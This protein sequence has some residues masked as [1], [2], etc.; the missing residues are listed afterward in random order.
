M[1]IK[2][3]VIIPIY[4]TCEYIEECLQS[5]CSQTLKEIEIICVDDGS[6]DGSATIVS[7]LQEKD[8]RIRLFEQNKC[9]SGP[10]RNLGIIKSVGEFIAFMDSDD[11]YP[12][13]KTLENMYIFAKQNN[14]QICGGSVSFCKNKQI[15]PQTH[16]IYEQGYIFKENSIMDYINYQFDHGYWRFIYKSDLIKRNSI[17]FP[18]FLRMQDPPFFIQAMSYSKN[19]YA[20]KEATYVY[21]VSHKKVQWDQHKAYDVVCGYIECLKISEN[22]GYDDLHFLL[23][24]RLH[25]IGIIKIINSFIVN[26]DKKFILLE[27]FNAINFR[28]VF[29]KDRQFKMHNFFRFLFENEFASC[30]IGAVDR[31]KDHLAYKLGSYLFDGN[32]NFILSFFQL[33]KIYKVH[34]F[35]KELKK[36]ILKN[37]LEYDPIETYLDCK[38]ALRLK[39]QPP[40]KLGEALIKANKTWYKG[41]YVKLI[42]EIRKLKKEFKKKANHA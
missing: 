34:M 15:L 6:T 20:M 33:L 18:S 1:K 39:N 14:V 30:K 13:T 26:S 22:N 3:S 23:V 28:L 41:G 36:I 16:K 12:N 32:R 42:F 38:E 37:K 4:N 7:L 10:A 29:Q 25:N 35:K 17:L 31:V 9:G 24:K 27:L 21:R 19:F 8:S 40:Y 5:V 11:F 2:I